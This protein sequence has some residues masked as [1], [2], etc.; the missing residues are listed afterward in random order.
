MCRNPAGYTQMSHNQQNIVSVR[1]L[2]NLRRPRS[3]IAAGQ[4]LHA[5]LPNWTRQITLWL[6]KF[7]D[8]E[9]TSTP[10]HRH[11]ESIFMPPGPLQCVG[12]DFRFLPT[13]FS[14]HFGE[15]GRAAEAKGLKENRREHP[16]PAVKSINLLPSASDLRS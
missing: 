12:G 2:F 10:T 8:H 16:L 7:K 4:G 1:V 15:R 14:S 13:F 3:A 6:R 5:I 11:S 9:M